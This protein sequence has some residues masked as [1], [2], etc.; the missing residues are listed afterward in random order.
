M[1]SLFLQNKCLNRDNCRYAHSKEELKPLPD[2]ANTK[3]CKSVKKNVICTDPNCKY[4]HHVEQLQPSTDLST[5]KITICHYWKKNKCMNQDK[6][7]FAHG[8]KEIR[9]FQA[10]R[11]A[12]K[13]EWVD[14]KE[15]KNLSDKKKIKDYILRRQLKN[16]NDF[17]YNKNKLCDTESNEITRES[18]NA[19]IFPKES[20]FFQNVDDNNSSSNNNS[21]INKLTN[22]NKQISKDIKQLITSFDFLFKN[23]FTS[24]QLETS[25]DTY[26]TLLEENDLLNDTLKDPSNDPSIDF[27]ND[28]S[29]DLSSDFLDEP[30]DH[31]KYHLSFEES[32]LPITFNNSFSEQYKQPTLNRL[33]HLRNGISSSSDIVTSLNKNV[34][35]LSAKS[36]YTAT[37][38]VRDSNLDKTISNIH[39]NYEDTDAHN[40][41]KS[42]YFSNYLS[43]ELNPPTH[44]QQLSQPQ[45]SQ[46]QLSQSQLSQSHSLSQSQLS[47]SQLSQP[48]LSQSQLS[49][50]QIQMQNSDDIPVSSFNLYDNF[51][52]DCLKE[53]D[54]SN[55]E[56]SMNDLYFEENKH[57]NSIPN[58]KGNGEEINFHEY[59]FLR[60]FRNEYISSNQ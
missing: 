2:L 22:V 10:K 14:N 11:N 32:S 56:N 45:L 55:I 20:S 30:L 43:M 50:P 17:K 21:C 33:S 1:C 54:L 19:G 9:S 37:N 44:L 4:A 48:Q 6:C 25:F 57:I 13:E 36:L 51:F 3:L 23:S 35:N 16:G 47:Q 28:L 5:Y 12:A 15:K 60:S 42:N 7:R 29:N 46:S 26:N 38:N 34:L 52:V 58:T 49:Q 8:T 41:Y 53:L 18:T 24:P 59:P 27:S 40:L 31:F 39:R